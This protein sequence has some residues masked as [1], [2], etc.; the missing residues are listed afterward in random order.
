MQ[1]VFPSQTKVYSVADGAGVPHLAGPGPVHAV[2][3]GQKAH[4]P[5]MHWP[6]VPHDVD[7]CATHMPC[8]SFPD[9]TGEQVPLAQLLAQY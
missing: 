7:G 1:L 6:V 8:G 5:F 2:P 3:C 9:G 4:A